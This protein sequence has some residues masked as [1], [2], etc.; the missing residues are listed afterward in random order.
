MQQIE[1]GNFNQPAGA[2]MLYTPSPVSRIAEIVIDQYTLATGRDLKSLPVSVVSR[3]ATPPAALQKQH[4]APPRQLSAHKTN[5]QAAH[6][7]Q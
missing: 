7:G 1:L 4:A 2:Q 3:A 6:S 5:A